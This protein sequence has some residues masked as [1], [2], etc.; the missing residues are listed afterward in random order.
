LG[1]GIGGAV[2]TGFKKVVNKKATLYMGDQS[3][4]KF[5]RKMEEDLTQGGSKIMFR[6]YNSISDTYIRL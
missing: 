5:M 6:R 1:Y 2:A 3:D 4:V